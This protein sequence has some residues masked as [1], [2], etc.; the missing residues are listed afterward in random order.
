MLTIFTWSGTE[1]RAIGELFLWGVMETQ[2]ICEPFDDIWST[3]SMT[4]H[5]SQARKIH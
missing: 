3:D 4:G 2:V 5:F 1:T